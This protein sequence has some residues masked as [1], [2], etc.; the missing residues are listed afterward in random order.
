MRLFGKNFTVDKGSL[1]SSVLLTI[2]FY[3][4]FYVYNAV[5]LG[6]ST[7]SG[8]GAFLFICAM[9]LISV[10]L[11]YC[12]LNFVF[13]KIDTLIDQA[14][15]MTVERGIF[16]EVIKKNFLPFFFIIML[17]WIPIMIVRY[18]GNIDPDTFWQ[19]LQTRGLALASDHHPWF[20][21]LL[22]SAFWSIGDLLGSHAW[23]LL[24]YCSLQM[25]C[26][27]GALA[28]CLCYMKWLGVP[29]VIR[30][31][32]LLFVTVLPMIPM[33]AQVMAKDSLFAWLWLLFLLLYI[34]VLRSEGAFLNNRKMSVVFFAICLLLTVT[35]KTGIYLILLSVIPL[36]LVCPCAR[37]R[38]G[39]SF[40]CSVLA[41][42]L[43]TNVV[44]PAFGVVKGS[45]AEMMSIP[46]QQ[47]AYYLQM[48]SEEMTSRDWTVLEGVYASP[49]VLSTVY[50]PARADATKGLWKNESSLNQKLDFFAW[51]IR[52]SVRHPK[53]FILGALATMLPLYY[54][55]DS[56]EGDESL[57]F[58]RDNLA[59]RETGDAGL[60]QAIQRYSDGLAN[61]EDMNSL[62]SGCFRN[63][64]IA[65]LSDLYDSL[66]HKI[67][68]I[69]PPLFY[70]VTYT[71]YLPFI[72]AFYCFS[73]FATYRS[74][75]Y[76][77]TVI[78]GFTPMFWM[79]LSLLAGPI[80]LPRYMG[81]A[82][83]AVPLVLALPFVL[84][85][86]HRR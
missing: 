65:K 83:Y 17:S 75:R 30:G 11:V 6:K 37:I 8:A 68:S 39:L 36:I 51:Y 18:P 24:F 61:D 86:C 72:M 49:E 7:L 44:L 55:D 74:K 66:L 47:V 57:L 50:Q 35:K 21:T 43:W 34:E 33:Y 31:A 3:L 28:L 80:A 77:I 38:I 16:K 5:Y 9:L 29:R 25:V 67:A 15:S 81:P 22:F 79:Y 40:G 46:S 20:D 48:H 13:I 23:S 41:F 69:F 82:I 53:T 78:V 84:L 32:S 26:T 19:L 27:S 60:V 63:P 10:F 54:P 59:S 2:S 14:Q 45:S 56:T 71:F 62:F 12:P 1:S 73:R 70:K 58:Y 4:G 76:P 85:Q 42:M 64:F 52:K